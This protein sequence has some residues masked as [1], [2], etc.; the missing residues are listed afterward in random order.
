MRV[1]GHATLAAMSNVLQQLQGDMI[2][3]NLFAQM[4]VLRLETFLGLPCYIKV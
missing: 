2:R 3:A 4:T 1:L